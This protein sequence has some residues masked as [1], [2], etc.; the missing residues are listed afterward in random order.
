MMIPREFAISGSI[1]HV[2]Y[3]WN[4]TYNK[5]RVDGLCMPGEKKIMI[6]RSLSVEDKFWTFI[7]EF[8]H[9][10]IDENELGH[11]SPHEDRSLV[12]DHEEEILAAL[13]SELRKNFSMRWRKK[14]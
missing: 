3:K 8:I 5:Q 1:W 14:R 12:L 2:E 9:A 10:V 11:N 6:D 7:H 13:E 4:L